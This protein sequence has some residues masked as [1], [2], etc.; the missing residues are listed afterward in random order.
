MPV[1]YPGSLDFEYE[2]R[3]FDVRKD[4]NEDLLKYT[5]FMHPLLKPLFPT[6]VSG[7]KLVA[8]C[9]DFWEELNKADYVSKSDN[10]QLGR[11]F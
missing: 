6:R 10:L 2:M 5:D 9:R 1:P 7:E 11:S 8:A 3:N 4:F